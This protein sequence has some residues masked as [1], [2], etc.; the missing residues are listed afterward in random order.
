MLD[1]A[2]HEAR[3][4]VDLYNRSSGERTLEAF[5]VHMHL[6]WLYMLQARFKR[7]GVDYRYRKPNGHFERVDGEPKTWDLAR[8]LR[9]QPPDE[10]NSVRLNVEFSSGSATR[11]S[12]VTSGSS[13]PP[14][15]ARRRPSS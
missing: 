3:L 7:D 14:S 11:S 15:R 5:V 6:A 4:A 2:K 13:R 8:C 10:N 9:E 12:T 1:A